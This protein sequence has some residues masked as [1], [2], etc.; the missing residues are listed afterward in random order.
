MANFPGSLPNIPTS[1]SNETLLLAAGIGHTALHNLIN[2]EI[3][4]IATKLGTGASTPSNGLFLMGNGAG[5]SAWRA[6][7]KTDVGLDQVDNTS[8]AT[9][10][11]AAVT[12]TNKTLTSP[13]LTT[14][15]IGDFTNATHTHA[16]TA[17]GGPINQAGLPLGVVV[18]VASTLSS[19]VATGT[20]TIPTDDTIPQN[21]EGDQYMTCTLTPLAIT[22][23]LVIMVSL[24]IS[25]TAATAN[26]IG[27]LFQDSNAN[28][29]AA[30][31]FTQQVGTGIAPFTITHTMAAGTIS[32]TTFKVR[33]GSSSG[34]TTTFNGSGGGRLFGAI[35]KSSI[36]IMEYKS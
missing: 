3:L 15:T 2:G 36:V 27:A 16:N 5:T 31:L 4:A 8:D 1:S 32:A 11:A 29:L 7:L 34:G 13:I 30:N 10:N 20:T 33:A 21:T 26:I 23:T 24:Y 25:H 22:N 9:K 14:P 17:G 18:Q 12:L 28:A 19:A 6:G 35:T